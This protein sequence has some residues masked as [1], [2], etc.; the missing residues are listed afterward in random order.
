MLV[1]SGFLRP[2]SWFL[3]WRAENRSGGRGGGYVSE[4]EHFPAFPRYQSPEARNEGEAPAVREADRPHIHGLLRCVQPLDLA[5]SSLQISPSPSTS[6]TAKSFDTK[7][8]ILE[9]TH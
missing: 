4:G 8:P 3:F 5:R 9:S 7:D 2:L 1:G 6:P